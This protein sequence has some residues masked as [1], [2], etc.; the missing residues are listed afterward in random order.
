MLDLCHTKEDI[1]LTVEA[2]YNF[3]GNFTRFQNTDVDNMI[4]KA[5]QLKE[6]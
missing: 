6:P 2:Y 3:K 4:L 5:V 1:Q